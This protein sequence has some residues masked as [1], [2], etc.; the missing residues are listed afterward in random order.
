MRDDRQ[1]QKVNLKRFLYLLQL[2]IIYIPVFLL[3]ILI[4]V[5][6]DKTFKQCHRE[7]NAKIK[8]EWNKL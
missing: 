3:N 5:S 2:L 6:T 1:W 8:D 7:S 4:S